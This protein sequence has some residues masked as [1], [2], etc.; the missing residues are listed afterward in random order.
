MG[1]PGTGTGTATG[2][3]AVPPPSNSTGI[4]QFTGAAIPAYD[5]PVGWSGVGW[6]V[7]VLGAGLLAGGAFLV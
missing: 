1:P 7:A 5:V 6:Q 4:I 2:T 3:G